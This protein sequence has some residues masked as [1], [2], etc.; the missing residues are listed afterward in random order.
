M[1]KLDIKWSLDRKNYTFIRILDNEEYIGIEDF[2]FKTYTLLRLKDKKELWTFTVTKGKNHFRKSY[3]MGNYIFLQEEDSKCSFWHVI[4]INTGKAKIVEAL[5]DWTFFHFA[6][7]DYAVFEVD[8]EVVVIDPVKAKPIKVQGSQPG[9]RCLSYNQGR[10]TA[11][12]ESPDSED[13]VYY[14]TNFK[15]DD[16][17]AFVDQKIE[18]EGNA[19]K[20]ELGGGYRD[21]NYI[22]YRY[23]EKRYRSNFAVFDWAG[24]YLHD[25]DLSGFFSKDEKE[26]QGMSFGNGKFVFRSRNSEKGTDK[27]IGVDLGSSNEPW[28]LEMGIGHAPQ[29]KNVIQAGRYIV[30]PIGKSGTEKD[31]IASGEANLTEDHVTRILDAHTGKVNIIHDPIDN[32]VI[33]TDKGIYYR[34]RGEPSFLHYAEFV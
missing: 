11:I 17:V 1:P 29:M 33:G 26:P 7:N 25:L 27:F 28:C 14:V 22:L 12:A 10:C 16:A 6:L 20:G 24:N 9:F 8:D 34:T 15:I 5:N 32:Y 4:D 2:N 13:A 21:S 23:Y 3:S 19:D 30:S 18:L 31:F